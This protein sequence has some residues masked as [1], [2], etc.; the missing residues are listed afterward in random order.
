MR[1]WNQGGGWAAE[2]RRLQ[3]GRTGLGRKLAGI[4]AL[5][6]DHEDAIEADPD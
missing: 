6:L 3:A 5:G 1:R 2:Y 4:N